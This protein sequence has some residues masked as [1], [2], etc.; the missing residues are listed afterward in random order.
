MIEVENTKAEVTM[1][2]AVVTMAPAVETNVVAMPVAEK[3]TKVKA[4]A[5][6]LA[7]KK[8]VKNLNAQLTAL[9][10][11]LGAQQTKNEI[12]FRE[13]Y[14]LKKQVEAQGSKEALIM[15]VMSEKIR[16]LQNDLIVMLN[17]K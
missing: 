4:V 16:M 2:P 14:D 7:L 3:S 17:T 5:S 13:N 15:Q 9:Q 11:D 6:E 1:A 10:V 12:L 8:E